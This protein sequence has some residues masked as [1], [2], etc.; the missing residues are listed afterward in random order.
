MEQIHLKL[1][2][3]RSHKHIPSSFNMNI[4]NVDWN[5]PYKK[6]EFEEKRQQA[7]Q[8]LNVNLLST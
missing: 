2:T 5:Q 7:I 8:I 6:Y 3:L 4:R 1:V